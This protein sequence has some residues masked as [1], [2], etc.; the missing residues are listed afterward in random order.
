MENHIQNEDGETKE[1][2]KL[3]CPFC[4]CEYSTRTYIKKHI[5]LYCNSIEKH[6]KQPE[7][8]NSNLIAE[9]YHDIYSAKSKEK[10]TPEGL[11][12]PLKEQ[13]SLQNGTKLTTLQKGNEN[14][15]RNLQRVMKIVSYCFT[16]DESIG[17]IKEYLTYTFMLTD[18]TMLSIRNVDLLSSRKGASLSQQALRLRNR[19]KLRNSN[20]T[21]RKIKQNS[22]NLPKPD[23]SLIELNPSTPQPITK[24]IFVNTVP[25]FIN[26]DTNQ[27]ITFLSTVKHF[28]LKSFPFKKNILQF[29]F[30][31][32]ILKYWGPNK[33]FHLSL[34][35]RY[36]K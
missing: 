2:R 35:F 27:G 30:Q 22:Q 11:T 36:L 20:A 5:H 34:T 18:G 31:N 33:S 21:T 13:V 25:T 23:Q 19:N 26:P 3:S 16:R 14:L 10:Q 8:F 15:E 4:F 9:C 28:I 24:S 1:A 12:I 32:K 17:G 7:N 6:L 29:S